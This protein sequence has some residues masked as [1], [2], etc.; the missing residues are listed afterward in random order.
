MFSDG[1]PNNCTPTLTELP[2][3][4]TKLEDVNVHSRSVV[5][6]MKLVVNIKTG[7]INAW[8]TVVLC[9]CEVT[10]IKHFA[11]ISLKGL[12]VQH[13]I[14]FGHTVKNE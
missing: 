2:S 9:M 7:L 13:V 3:F 12:H 1:V 5:N 4:T 14:I 8:Y 10:A 11:G 6:T